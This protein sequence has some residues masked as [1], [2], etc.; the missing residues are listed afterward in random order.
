MCTLGA[1]THTH[2]PLWTLLQSCMAQQPCKHSQGVP[3]TTQGEA[4]KHS[5]QMNVSFLRS[6]TITHSSL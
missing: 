1:Y 3:L 4:V 6:S 2:T 5:D